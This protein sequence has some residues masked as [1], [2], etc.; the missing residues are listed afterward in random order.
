MS[1]VKSRDGQKRT[2]GTSSGSQSKRL[3]KRCRMLASGRSYGAGRRTLP[4]LSGGLGLLRLRGRRL[5]TAG[6][7]GG[8]S[9]EERNDS[10]ELYGGW[11]DYRDLSAIQCQLR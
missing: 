4:L 9:R 6:Q 7:S 2:N 10:A 1:P 8:R 11:L 5:D 3:P